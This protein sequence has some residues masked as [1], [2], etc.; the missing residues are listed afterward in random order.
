MSEREVER[1]D[2]A[3]RRGSSACRS[4]STFLSMSAALSA[5]D[6]NATGPSC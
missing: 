6:A 2:V 4:F 1:R 5:A 3:G